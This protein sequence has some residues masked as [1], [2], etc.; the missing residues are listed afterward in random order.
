MCRL[1]HKHLTAMV[2][3]MQEAH[4]CLSCKVPRDLSVSEKL[5]CDWLFLFVLSLGISCQMSSLASLP[6]VTWDPDQGSRGACIPC[7]PYT[8]R[9]RDE[10][11]LCG[12]SSSGP[13]F[14]GRLLSWMNARFG[15]LQVSQ[16]RFWCVSTPPLLSDVTGTA[17]TGCAFC[18]WSQNTDRER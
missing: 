16:L 11:G 1:H 5:P 13:P 10:G 7:Q 17:V 8:A 9:T 15:W 3:I 14:P 2:G 18:W 4:R 6:K 12:S